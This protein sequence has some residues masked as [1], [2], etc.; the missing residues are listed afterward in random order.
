MKPPTELEFE[1]RVSV[2]ITSATTAPTAYSIDQV[3]SI[4][5]GQVSGCGE[6]ELTIL[7]LLIPHNHQPRLIRDEGAFASRLEADLDAAHGAVAADVN[8]LAGAVHFVAD[9]HAFGGCDA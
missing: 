6:V 7:H 5:C 8:H 4:Q 2:V 9:Q 1:R 3:Q